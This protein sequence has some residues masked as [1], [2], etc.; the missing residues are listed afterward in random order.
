M[1]NSSPRSQLMSLMPLLDCFRVSVHTDW[2]LSSEYFFFYTFTVNF[3]VYSKVCRYPKKNHFYP[4]LGN[5]PR[6]GKHCFKQSHLGTDRDLTQYSDP[7]WIG[8]LTFHDV[9]PYLVWTSKQRGWLA[10]YR[11]ADTVV[12]VTSRITWASTDACKPMRNPHEWRFWEARQPGAWF[13]RYRVILLGTV[14][15]AVSSCYILNGGG[16]LPPKAIRSLPR[17]FRDVRN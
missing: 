10:E 1:H 17:S 8:V 11:L 15:L 9:S 14:R 6:F 3:N 4:I 12:A 5:L 16:V 2:S 13:R 7:E